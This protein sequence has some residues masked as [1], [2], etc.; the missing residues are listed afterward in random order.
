MAENNNDNNMIPEEDRIGVV[1]PRYLAGYVDTI[2]QTVLRI[3]GHLTSGLAQFPNIISIVP[4]QIIPPQVLDLSN[5]NMLPLTPSF[6]MDDKKVVR[7]FAGQFTAGPGMGLGFSNIFNLSTQVFGQ[8]ANQLTS[9]LQLQVANN[10]SV[11]Q[12]QDQLSTLVIAIITALYKP[13]S[14]VLFRHHPLAYY[15]A[16]AAI[17]VAGVGETLTAYWLSCSRNA[18]G[19]HFAVGKAVWWASV[20]SLIFVLGIGGC[21]VI[22]GY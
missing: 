12:L 14:G 8:V 1:L 6:H 7:H 2:S 9:G 17:F 22:M 10:N 20:V 15:C 4:M 5:F 16:L 18:N 13:A 21:R 11:L 19:R 3:T